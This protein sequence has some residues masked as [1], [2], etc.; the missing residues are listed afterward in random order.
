VLDSKSATF[1]PTLID[2]Y[3]TFLISFAGPRSRI[4]PANQ[5]RIVST[6]QQVAA[7]AKSGD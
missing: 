4:P 7:D 3:L 2:T 6:L 1:L 5:I